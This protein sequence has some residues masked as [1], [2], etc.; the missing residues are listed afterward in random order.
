[1]DDAN[2][3]GA[4]SNILSIVSALNTQSGNY[5]CIVT[6][7][8]NSIFAGSVTSSVCVL[9]VNTAPVPPHIDT[10]PANKTAYPL[11]NVTFSV[12]ASGPGTITYQWRSNSVPITGETGPTLTLS[13][14]TTAFQANYSVGVTNENGGVLS[15]NATLTVLTPQVVTIGFL[16][17]LVDQTTF[18]P[19]NT[20]TYYT[21]SGVVTSRTNLTGA[22]NA[23][24][25]IQDGTAGI[26]VFN[27]A[28]TP[29]QA[30]GGPRARHAQHHADAQGGGQMATGGTDA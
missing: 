21:A 13:Q 3:V 9:T 15:S 23:S 18:L 10:Q 22:A 14:V 8:T 25:T 24:F 7:T 30:G 11:Q 28:G 5:K 19:T 26:L 1:V 17:T 2:N 29:P 16:R 27:A 12:G 4:T 20:T 6:S